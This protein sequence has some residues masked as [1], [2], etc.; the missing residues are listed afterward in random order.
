MP[1]HAY[2]LSEFELGDTRSMLTI[3]YCLALAWRSPRK[4][5]RGLSDSARRLDT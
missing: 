3:C 4:D 1:T 5:C 2:T